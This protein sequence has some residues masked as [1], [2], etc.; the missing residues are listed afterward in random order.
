MTCSRFGYTD[1]EWAFLRLA[2]LLSGYFLRRHFNEFIGR[3][4]GALA[5]RFVARGIAQGHFQ[6][7]PAVGGRVIYHVAGCELYSALGDPNNRNRRGHRMETIRRRLLALDYALLQPETA[8]L[9]TEREKV[10]YFCGAS[11]GTASTGLGISEGDLPIALFHGKTDGEKTRRY[12]VDKQP[13]SVSA[14][15]RPQFA[16]IHEGSRVLSQWE[17]FLR[18]HR[19]LFQALE[20]A[21]VVFASFGEEHCGPAEK[22]FRRLIAGETV[23]G[24]FDTGRLLSFFAARKAFKEQRFEEFNQARLDELR[25]N[26]RVFVGSEVE[27]LYVAWLSGKENLKPRPV[28]V[29]F[30]QFKLP[31]FYEWLSPMRAANSKP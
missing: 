12:F 13:L 25:E 2:S 10:L 18:G 1:R 31:H 22:L 19:A 4:C 21:Q 20:A 16:F 5:Q 23:H 9:L 3:E 29:T 28:R 24:S 8:W 7:V 27:A 11:G 30:S 15:G 14:D 6:A 17:M 26:Q